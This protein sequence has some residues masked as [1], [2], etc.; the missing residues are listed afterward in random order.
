MQDTIRPLSRLSGK[1]IPLGAGARPLPALRAYSTR[2]MF[3]N[4][5]SHASQ[6][7]IACQQ[8]VYD[9][10]YHAAGRSKDASFVIRVSVPLLGI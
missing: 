2:C 8:Y 10:S 6:F 7:P 4:S 9:A 3:L 5:Q 1:L